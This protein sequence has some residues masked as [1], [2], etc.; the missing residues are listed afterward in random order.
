MSRL[1]FA[2][3][4]TA[5]LAMVAGAMLFAAPSASAASNCHAW[6]DNNGNGIGWCDSGNGRWKVHGSCANVDG[7]HTGLEGSE[8]G[9]SMGQEWASVLNCSAGGGGALDMWV[10]AYG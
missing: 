9:R 7:V 4:A 6:T 1:R 10:E 2:G 3:T 5:A 8:G